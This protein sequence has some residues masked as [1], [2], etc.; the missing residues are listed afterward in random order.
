VLGEE[1]L[2]QRLLAVDRDRASHEVDE[3]DVVALALEL[4]VDAVVGEAALAEVG[5]EAVLGEEVDRPLLQH[6]GPDA[7][8]HVLARL[9][10]EDH[11][12][13]AGLGQEMAEHQAGRAR[14]D[15]G[16]GGGLSHVHASHVVGRT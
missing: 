2:H 16:H 14:A 4:Q 11:E 5:V 15:D 12:R 1:V 6:P 13:H 8:E 9:R 3:V 10:L 7:T